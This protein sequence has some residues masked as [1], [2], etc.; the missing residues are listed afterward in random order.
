M[1]YDNLRY[2]AGSEGKRREFLG[3]WFP[4]PNHHPNTNPQFSPPISSDVEIHYM[5]WD[6][7][8]DLLLYGMSTFQFRSIPFLAHL[9]THICATAVKS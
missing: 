1:M 2:L 7:G 9:N 8:F 4:S 6:K 3:Q 5:N